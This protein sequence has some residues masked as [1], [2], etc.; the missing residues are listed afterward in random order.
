[1]T[2]ANDR[3]TIHITPQRALEFGIIKNL[4]KSRGK[5]SYAFQA[6]SVEEKDGKVRIAARVDGKDAS[7]VYDKATLDRSQNVFIGWSYLLL[8]DDWWID[9]KGY[10]KKAAAYIKK[11]IEDERGAFPLIAERSPIPYY[12]VAAYDLDVQLLGSIKDKLFR[13]IPRQQEL[14]RDFYVQLLRKES[15]P[16][17]RLSVANIALKHYPDDPYFAAIVADDLFSQQKWSDCIE[18]LSAFR[19]RVGHA[20]WSNMESLRFTLFQCFLKKKRYQD[21]L[22]DL[23]TP[24]G[25]TGDYTSL[26]RGMIHFEQKQWSVATR[27][28]EKAVMDDYRDDTVSVLASYYLIKCYRLLKNN[29]RIEGIVASFPLRQHDLFFPGVPFHYGDNARKL[30]TEAVKYH[31]LEAE[32]QAKLQAMLATV[33]YE[34]L[35]NRGEKKSKAR[36]TPAVT[37]RLKTA[38]LYTKE[39][40]EYFPRQ[41][42]LNSLC[43]NLLYYGKRFDEAMDY[44]LRG[45][46]ADAGFYA[47]VDLGE[48]S[49]EYIDAYAKSVKKALDDGDVAP[50]NYIE[51]DL[52]VDL[53]VLWDKKYYSH[54]AEL[55]G[56]VE[57]H[58]SDYSKIGQMGE[59]GVGLFEIAYALAQVGENA[60][61]QRVYEIHIKNNGE[62]SSALNNL[63]LLYE[64]RGDLQ[65]ARETI[66]RAKV[67]GPKDEFVLRN[68]ERLLGSQKGRTARRERTYAHAQKKKPVPTFNPKTGEI[69]F[70]NKRCA[71]PLSSRTHLKNNA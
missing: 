44:K 25:E 19:K 11:A 38:A 1:M 67:K 41:A 34:L 7:L 2:N 14:F 13:F 45:A 43:S 4:P 12:L 69:V 21:A 27:D 55:Y 35:P 51:Y 49:K 47:D 9:D 31:D 60:D 30:L 52:E 40:L 53:R 36:L 63:A 17:R 54:I 42:F 32:T 57:P 3:E 58:I 59:Y 15:N 33:L 39:A 61:A 10:K 50:K 16:L 46:G 48:C 62:S 37:Q 8:H 71:I 20:A 6:L 26:L 18:Y 22:A 29:A 56:Y 23:Q 68:Y 65:K 24:L 64:K 70:G 28:F 5:D 66:K